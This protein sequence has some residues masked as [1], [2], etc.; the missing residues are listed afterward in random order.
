MESAA[1][2]SVKPATKR[3]WRYCPPRKMSTSVRAFVR[4]AKTREEGYRRPLKVAVPIEKTGS[5]GAGCASA[6]RADGGTEPGREGLVAEGVAVIVIGVGKDV[7]VS[8]GSARD[9]LLLGPLVVKSPMRL[10]ESARSATTKLRKVQLLM[11]VVS[12]CVIATP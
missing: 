6:L 7:T 4:E 8:T 9:G 3:S 2:R 11:R 1:E 12:G 5:P 10:A